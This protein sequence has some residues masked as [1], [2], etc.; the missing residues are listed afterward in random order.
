M[1]DSTFAVG[2][3][4]EGGE[5]GL[6]RD[7]HNPFGR[8]LYVTMREGNPQEAVTPIY[9]SGPEQRPRFRRFGALVLT[10]G[11]RVLFFPPGELVEIQGSDVRSYDHLTLAKDWKSWHLTTEP[12]TDPNQKDHRGDWKT[13][14]L[15]SAGYHWFGLN[16]AQKEF[17][18][19]VRERTII[20]TGIPKKA[21]DDLDRRA[22]A[23]REATDPYDG[24]VVTVPEPLETDRFLHFSFFIGPADFELA[25]VD[26]PLPLPDRPE[27][28]EAVEKQRGELDFNAEPIPLGN[29]TKIWILSGWLPGSL[30]E[31]V[32]ISCIP[33]GAKVITPV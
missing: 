29:E 15:G 2:V 19:P 10:A 16:V 21:L 24:P 28:L 30:Q 1:S 7:P 4:I 27:V 8:A 26:P 17:L 5:A 6:D 20:E 23:I 14:P 32:S 33:S 12:T 31:H 3:R 25:Q 13:H 9:Y 11:E 22:V 18:R